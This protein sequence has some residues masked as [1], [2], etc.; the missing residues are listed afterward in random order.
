MMAVAR[1]PLVVRGLFEIGFLVRS[2]TPEDLRGRYWC[3]FVICSFKF[4]CE[5][6][7]PGSG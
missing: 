6:Q 4:A 1:Y 2:T 7:W 5:N 3:G